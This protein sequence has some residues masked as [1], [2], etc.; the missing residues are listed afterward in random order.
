MIARLKAALE[1]AQS[2]ALVCHLSPDMDTL[3]SAVALRYILE[4]Q[5]KRAVVYDQDEVPERYLF[6]EGL[7]A[8]RRP[9]DEVYDLA[10][11][12]DVSDEARMGEA[13]RVFA[14][15]RSRAMIDHHRTTAPFAPVYVLR[16]EAA[17]TAQIVAELCA[18]FGWEIP[19]PA[20][21]C[22]CAGM[23]TD[24]GNFS[25]DSVTGDTFRA[26]GACVDRGARVS[27]ITERLYRTSTLG[28]VRM[29]GRVL[30]GLE[31]RCGGKIA[32]LCARQSDFAELNATRE[33]T[34]TQDAT[35]RVVARGPGVR[36]ED[37]RAVLPRFVGEIEQ[38][39]PAYSA[40]KVGGRKL[41]EAARA[42]EALEVPSRRVQIYGLDLA[43][44]S[45]ENRF[46]LDVRCGRGT[47]I[48]TL[49]HDIGRA[50]G[51]CAHMAFLLRVRS[52]VFGIEDAVT[53]EEFLAGA[54][55]ARL[56]PLDA[57]LQHLPAVRLGETL[58]RAVRNGNPIRMEHWKRPMQ[59]G[60]VARIYLGQA[61]AGIGQ[62]Q[63]GRIR[64]RCMLLRGGSPQ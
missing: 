62:A 38:V 29:M 17:A 41:Y 59:E 39:P 31:M 5:G 47:Y 24:T 23:S 50:L 45:G 60:T 20:A 44:Q 37:L 4:A 10:L 8:V 18:R 56:M 2:V 28:H 35:G 64:F 3:G 9:D 11:A 54:P 16:P 15:A 13:A 26:A 57:P 61:F 58:E 55:D 25:F 42:G 46:L 51:T 27:A 53:P 30:N 63:E 1:G 40:I 6:L 33:A 34:D 22:L 43:G 36:M 21:M 14:A 52:G 49:C 32:L 12:V 48:R 7:D 19:Q